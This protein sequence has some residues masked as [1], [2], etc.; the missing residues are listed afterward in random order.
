[1]QLSRYLLTLSIILV[2]FIQPVAA[3]NLTYLDSINT[4]LKNT[5]SDSVR[6]SIYYKIGYEWVDYNVDSTHYFANLMMSHARRSQLDSDFLY[7]F[8]LKALAFDYEYKSDSAIAYY[9]LVMNYARILGDKSQLALSYFN[10]GTVHLLQANYLQVL[11]YYEE[12]MEIC[13]SNEGLE[14]ELGMIYNNLGIVY[15]RIRN[16]E[17]ALEI[18]L[19]AEKLQNTLDNPKGLSDLYL[20]IANNYISLENFEQAKIYY[21]KA[22]SLLGEDE[23]N[24][25][26]Q[27]VY[28]GL[29]V[30]AFE[31]KEY[32]LAKEY[33]IKSLKLPDLEDVNHKLIAYGYLGSLF[34]LE[35]DFR[36]AD[37]YFD[38]ALELNDEEKFSDQAKELFLQL[39]DFYTLKADFEV[40][41]TYL[42]KYIN[43]T[44]RLLNQEIIDR[45]A[46]WEERYKL[47]EKEKEIV[48]LQ[49]LNQQASLL[50]AQQKN[51]K[52]LF[53]FLT[54]ILVLITTFV[55]LQF[56]NKQKTNRVLSDKNKVISNSLA[57]KE[58]LMREIHHRVKNNLQVISSLLNMQTFFL[59]DKKANAAVA[60]SKNRVQAMSLIHQSLYSQEDLTLINIRDYL[61]Q[62][63]NNLEAGLSDTEKDII[64]STSIESIPVDVDQ[65]I[66]I[67]LIVN[68]LITNSFKYAFHG[69]EIGEISIS[70]SKKDSN[71]YLIIKDDG[72]GNN[73]LPMER[74]SSLGMRLLHDL[75]KKLK[76]ELD[77]KT[78]IGT[79]ISLIFP[80][81]VKLV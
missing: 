81:K 44:D 2:V 72:I 47:Q 46:E 11:P 45:T 77:I 12:A 67:G 33:F 59:E 10:I 50:N 39:A 34:A 60:D 73:G 57:E 19:R 13:E 5:T 4:V 53:G 75:S 62:L 17:K 69:K 66:P 14:E 42:R 35:K 25:F 55:G 52:N 56:W 36:Q 8:R 32:K 58:L 30:I 21:I 6:N 65:A 61:G 80:V 28:N 26:F 41:A 51:Q 38:K 64:I 24:N 7:A 70:F 54:V 29:G 3:Q 76:A 18:Y 43:L 68:E 71:Y 63:L 40:A 15:R 74:K 79:E 31:E 20:N 23:P 9:E 16:L 22:R 48:N 49:L 37:F 1:M 78:Q 27:Y